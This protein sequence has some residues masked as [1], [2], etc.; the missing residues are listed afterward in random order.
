[1]KVEEI[2]EEDKGLIVGALGPL[3]E[4]DTWDNLFE[5][6]RGTRSRMFLELGSPYLGGEISFVHWVAATS[7]YLELLEGT[8]LA[9]Q[10]RT[11]WIVPL[12]S[13]NSIPIQERLFN[14][15][16]NSVR[17]FKESELGPEDSRGEPLGGEV[18]NVVS[19]ELRQRIYRRLFCAVFGDYGNVAL[20]AQDP[21]DNFRPAVGVGLRYGLPIGPVRLDV[22][23]NPAKRPHENLYAIHLAIGMPY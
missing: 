2:F 13:T 16:E 9:G 6:T 23:F 1:V 21:W 18:K 20:K 22:G 15:G 7:R 5:P 11:E 4:Y 10:L 17:S 14:G 8:V 3:I 12:G 19:L